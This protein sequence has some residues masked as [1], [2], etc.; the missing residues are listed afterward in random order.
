ME[1]IAPA[2]DVYQAGTLVGEPAG[3][4]R[5]PRHARAARRGGLRPTRGPHRAARRRPARGGRRAPVQVVSA[6]GLLTVFFTEQPVHDYDGRSGVRPRGLRRLVPRRCWRAASTRRRRSSRPG[7][8]RSRTRPSTSRARSRRPPRPSPPSNDAGVD[9][10]C[11]GSPTSWRRRPGCRTGRRGRP[12]RPRARRLGSPCGPGPRA[13]G[14]SDYELLVESIRE[15]YELHYGAPRVVRTDDPDLALLAGDRLYALGLERLGAASATCSPW[16]RARGRHLLERAGPGGG[17]PGARRGPS[18][19][20]A[21]PRSAGARA[22]TTRRARRRARRGAPAPPP[23]CGPPRAERRR[24][25][26]AAAESPM[27]TGLCD[28]R[29]VVDDMVP[30]LLH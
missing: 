20:P 1:R 19:R 26:A 12:L 4:R 17:R 3:R 13:A 7:S 27:P 30:P 18:G 22:P 16:R 25:G 21:R 28:A 10:R 24:P 6:P 5:G 23:R 8:R 29:L 15:G 2:G 9:P 14:T 11:A